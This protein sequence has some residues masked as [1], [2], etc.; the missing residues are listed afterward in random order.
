MSYHEK[1]GEPAYGVFGTGRK[2]HWHKLEMVF[3]TGENSERNIR[4]M[5]I[6]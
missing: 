1:W 4:R 2:Y 5:G 6:S 3:T